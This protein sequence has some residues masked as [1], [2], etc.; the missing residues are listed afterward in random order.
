[1]DILKGMG[2]KVIIY[3]RFRGE[4]RSVVNGTIFTQKLTPGQIHYPIKDIRNYFPL[5]HLTWR[6]IHF[7]DIPAVHWG[8]GYTPFDEKVMIELDNAN[9]IF[10]DCEALV[11]LPTTIRTT[12]PDGRV[13]YAWRWAPKFIQYCH[14]PMKDLPPNRNPDYQPRLILCNSQFTQKAVREQW[15]TEA[16]VLYPPIYCDVFNH[17]KTMRE[18]K[19]DL[20]FYARLGADKYAFFGE[21]MH[22]LPG[23]KVAVIG[24]NYGLNDLLFKKVDL[25]RNATFDT[26][27]NILGD[28]RIYIHLKGL[29]TTKELSEHFG[30]TICDSAASG[31]LCF[32]PSTPSG[33]HEIPGVNVYY[34]VNDL[35]DQVKDALNTMRK[36]DDT[37]IQ[38]ERDKEE[39][40]KD[41]IIKLD[42]RFR[43]KEFQA[44]FTL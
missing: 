8:W 7:A 22:K 19:Y 28:S 26:I 31:C 24:S 29:E 5:K 4:T 35:V 30:Q 16:H 6:D 12:L 43:K 25:F 11:Q 9:M 21:I 33:S 23:L 3:D 41:T 1:M 37:S 10:T 20:V 17:T 39:R 44:T 40:V 36:T 34:T 14:Y 2:H 42:P 32:T 27:T 13:D 38:V 18:R 15:H